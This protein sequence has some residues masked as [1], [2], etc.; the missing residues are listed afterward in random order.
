MT[1]YDKAVAVSN[2][3]SQL[4]QRLARAKSCLNDYYSKLMQNSVFDFENKR[5]VSKCGKYMLQWL[6][7]F[8]PDAPISYEN[9]QTNVG[10]VILVEIA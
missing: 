9:Q 5:L 6:V 10:C 3:K 2:N 8:K 1:N 7:R 4:K